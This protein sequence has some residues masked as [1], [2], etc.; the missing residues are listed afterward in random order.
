VATGKFY[1]FDVGVAN[2]LNGVSVLNPNS[3]DFGKS[4]E[5]FI[6]MELRAYLSYRRIKKEL[7]YWRS[8]SGAEVDFLIGNDIAIDVK[9]TSRVNDKHLKGLRVLKEE[10]LIGQFFLV[11]LDEVERETSGGIR[12]LHWQ[13]FLERLWAGSL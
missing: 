10:N 8:Q 6:A 2:F 3:P 5:Q 12:L 1:F 13:N 9:A 11:S 4:F 7:S